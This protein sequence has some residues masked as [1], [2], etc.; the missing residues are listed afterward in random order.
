MNILE[1]VEQMFLTP[2]TDDIL[3]TL[4]CV[5]LRSGVHHILCFACLRLVCPV[6]PVSLD[7]PFFHILIVSKTVL[8]YRT[9]ICIDGCTE[10]EIQ[11]KLILHGLI[12]LEILFTKNLYC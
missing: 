7:C 8:P 4:F 1:D 12:A 5:C 10:E 2:L 6:L 3:F 9:N 11:M